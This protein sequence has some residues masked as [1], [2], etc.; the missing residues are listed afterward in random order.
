MQSMQRLR[1]PQLHDL[2]TLLPVLAKVC[3]EPPFEDGLDKLCCM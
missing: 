2:R 3:V 1:L